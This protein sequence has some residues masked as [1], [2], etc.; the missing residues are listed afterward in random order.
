[1]N[2][3]C[4]TKLDHNVLMIMIKGNMISRKVK[5]KA[6]FSHRELKSWLLIYCSCPTFVWLF[7][8]LF[9]RGQMRFRCELVVV[10]N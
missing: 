2:Y 4:H 5:C 3:W 6:M 10:L 1:M 8:S 7:A 9:K